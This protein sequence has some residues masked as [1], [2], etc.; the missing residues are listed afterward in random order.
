MP[1]SIKT[2]MDGPVRMKNST[3]LVRAKGRRCRR[4]YGPVL[5]LMP[6]FVT[7]SGC[8][9]EK[10]GSSNN[11]ET[12]TQPP[13]VELVREASWRP[14]N[15]VVGSVVLRRTITLRSA[16]AG[17]V[18]DCAAEIGETVKQGQ[19]L[20]RLTGPQV[21][22]PRQMIEDELKILGERQIKSQADMQRYSELLT[23]DLISKA[24]KELIAARAVVHEQALA[25]EKLHD[26]LQQLEAAATVTVPGD[27]TI[28]ELSVRDGGDVV[29]DQ[30]LAILSVP[31]E[32]AIEAPILPIRDV[33]VRVGTRV[34]VHLEEVDAPLTLHVDYFVPQAERSTGA[35]IVG[36]L[37]GNDAG[38]LRQRQRIRMDLLGDEVRAVV[39]PNSSVVLRAGK[40]FCVKRSGDTWQAV[41]VKLLDS[42][43]AGHTFLSD[44][45]KPGDEV[46]VEGAYGII[47]R[48]FRE[49]FRFED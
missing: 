29:T 27:G 34:L 17:R 19:V 15:S 24:D 32:V 5:F 13:K 47:Y 49:L 11:G 46:V 6:F 38:Q 41:E 25:I 22:G 36:I 18:A 48:D 45:L 7:S 28:V 16:H 40:A 33:R 14:R 35:A 10:A 2:K 12:T 4:W 43:D 8:G 23:K 42:D 37:P 26:E 1:L 3:K 31:S 39:V 9:P 20:L 30:A 21:A 44:G